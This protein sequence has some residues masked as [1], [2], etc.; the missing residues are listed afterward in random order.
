MAFSRFAMSHSTWYVAPKSTL[1]TSD[2]AWNYCDLKCLQLEAKAPGYDF[3]VVT[4]KN[5]LY[6][7]DFAACYVK[8]RNGS[9]SL[10][11]TV[12]NNIFF[13]KYCG[14]DT[15]DWLN[16]GNYVIAKKEGEGIGSDI[17]Y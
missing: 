15:A 7:P 5:A 10:W 2:V 16:S 4:F 6:K 17:S 1:D 12:V 14:G 8:N 11:N 3:L 9:F 13:E